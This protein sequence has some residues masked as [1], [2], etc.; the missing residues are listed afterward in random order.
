MVLKKFK[1]YKMSKCKVCFDAGKPASVYNS[2]FVKSTDRKR[3]VCPTLLALKC[4]YCEGAG[5][6]IKYC[7]MLKKKENNKKC[8][9]KPV[10][11]RAA[12]VVVTKAAATNQFAA[13]EFDDDDDQIQ[14]VAEVVHGDIVS[15]A[16]ALNKPAAALEIPKLVRATPMR[17]AD[18][19]T[20]SDDDDDFQF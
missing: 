2:H 10:E 4:R 11:E 15:Y 13:L 16:A 5:H 19:D 9:I 8:Y 6:T 7:E 3:V 1:V 14:T 18:Y 20:D 17:W 12:V